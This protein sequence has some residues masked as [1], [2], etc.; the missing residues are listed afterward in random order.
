MKATT[1]RRIYEATV[2]VAAITLLLVLAVMAG[3][4]M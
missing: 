1:Y 2:F 4:L 3:R